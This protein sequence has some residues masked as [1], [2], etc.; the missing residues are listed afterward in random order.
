MR[1]IATK[2]FWRSYNSLPNDIQKIAE[3][4]FELLKSAPKHP[5]LNLKKI[6]ELWPVRVGLSHRALGIDHDEGIAWIWIGS[7]SEYDR[8]I[9]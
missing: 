1:H 9:R 8:L 7:H 5:S 6:K 4:N 3:K 2:K